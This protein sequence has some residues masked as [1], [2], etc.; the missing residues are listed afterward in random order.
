MEQILPVAALTAGA[1]LAA[2]IVLVAVRLG[3]GPTLVDRALALDLLSFVAVALVA[4]IVLWTG[5]TALFDPAMALALI[6][7]LATVALA[8]FTMKT[9][10]RARSLGEDPR[11]GGPGPDTEKTLEAIDGS[12]SSHHGPDSGEGEEGFAGGPGG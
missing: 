2:A 1:L 5:Q 6:A 11:A 12:I 3:I 10:A 4:V 8:R 7:F 9:D